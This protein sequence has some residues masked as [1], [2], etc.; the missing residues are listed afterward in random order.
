[1][2]LVSLIALGLVP[3]SRA[4]QLLASHYTGTLYTLDLT[5]NHTLSISSSTASGA[6]MPSWLAFDADTRTVY[7]TD[8]SW[9]G[10]GT[11]AS[12]AISENGVA[13]PSGSTATPGGDIHCSLF[14]G[15][16]GNAFIAVPN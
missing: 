2:A 14:G 15:D 10:S 1:M 6:L 4:A 7:V 16:S 9:F 8:E 12:L 13:T 5:D 11:L 3:L